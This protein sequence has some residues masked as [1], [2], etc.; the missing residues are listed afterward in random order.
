MMRVLIVA[1]LLFPAAALAQTQAVEFT[2][3]RAGQPVSIRPDRAYIFYRV[4]KMKG[5]HLSE[6]I[7][8]REFDRATG[9]RGYNLTSGRLGQFYAE[10]ATERF[11][12]I[13]A[14]PA[15][16]VI[17]GQGYGTHYAATCYCM[18][19][20]R[21]VAKAGVLTDLGYLLSDDPSNLSPFPELR[22]V[23]GRGQR[24]DDGT[25]S[26]YVGAIRPVT[27][28]APVP[29]AL[30]GL[31]REPAQFRAVG[32]FRNSFAFLINRL[33]PLDGVL[34][35]DEDRVIDLQAVAE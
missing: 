19:T 23:S 28:D 22:A 3:I 31:P 17:A 33:A 25:N 10:T 7:F 35:Y 24:I 16:Y 15:S 4:P 6:T 8:L 30:R 21:F 29:A 20:V 5:A 27:A 14:E 9:P 32:K 26:I 34:A 1:A 13:E 2:Q 12:L 11:Y 18:G